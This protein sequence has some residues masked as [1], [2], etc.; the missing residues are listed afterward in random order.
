MRF[1]IS[2]YH[3]DGVWDGLS[4]EEQQRHGG[5]LKD[6]AKALKDEKNA[7]MVF[8]NPA[9]VRHL[10]QDEDGSKR[11]KEGP[12]NSGL[13]TMGGY[14][15]IDADD[16]EVAEVWADKARFMT[17]SNEIREIAVFR[18]LGSDLSRKHLWR[19]R[20]PVLPALP[21]AHP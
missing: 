7:E 5:W 12:V 1:M 10:R 8:L 15:I 19:G 16:W 14:F 4:P 20:V 2:F 11:V 3:Q 13:G 18:P 9:E 21:S 17:G 6:F